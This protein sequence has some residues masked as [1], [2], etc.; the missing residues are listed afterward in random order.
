MAIGSGLSR[1]T[2]LATSLISIQ[3]YFIIWPVK[4]SETIFQLIYCVKVGYEQTQSVSCYMNIE[5]VLFYHL[6]S[7]DIMFYCLVSEDIRHYVLAKLLYY[8][9]VILAIEIGLI[10]HTVL[11]TPWILIQFYFILLPVKIENTMCYLMYWVKVGY[12]WPL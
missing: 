5:T 7:E 9:W 8:I 2:V 4:I 1:H 11:A 3:F 6:T 10:R 12:F